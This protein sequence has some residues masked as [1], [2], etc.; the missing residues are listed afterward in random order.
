MDN[1]FISGELAADD[2]T[3]DDEISFE[4]LEKNLEDELNASSWRNL[5]RFLDGGAKGYWATQDLLGQK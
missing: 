2:E 3:A 4:S 5:I 1:R